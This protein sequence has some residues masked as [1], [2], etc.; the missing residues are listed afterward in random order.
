MA[1]SASTTDLP[2]TNPTLLGKRA[3]PRVCE[4]N[5]TLRRLG[6]SPNTRPASAADCRRLLSSFQGTDDGDED[7]RRL[8]VYKVPSAGVG[9]HAAKAG[10][11]SIV[12][13]PAASPAA[14]GKLEFALGPGDLADIVSAAYDL[15]D[16]GREEIAAS[17][18][19]WNC[20]DAEM[21][22]VKVD[23]FVYN[24]GRD[25]VK[26]LPSPAGPALSRRA[27]EP[28]GKPRGKPRSGGPGTCTCRSLGNSYY[29]P[30]GAVAMA[31]IAILSLFLVNDGWGLLG[32]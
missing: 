17:G 5:A 15:M 4:G 25:E 13:S 12:L 1:A 28:R 7:T 18:S 14:A 24:E 11:C 3:L 23:W 10:S 26:P 22:H 2:S 20:Q 21:K 27:P 9:V 32:E 16:T 31:S 19:D 30:A 6:P 8:R 29:V